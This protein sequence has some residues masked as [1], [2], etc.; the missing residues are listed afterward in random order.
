MNIVCWKDAIPGKV[1]A[2]I[3]D[4]AQ[5]CQLPEQFDTTCDLIYTWM[6]EGKI[7]GV[8]AFKTVLFS[9]GQMIPR[10]E[11]IFGTEDVRK[12][13]K[14]VKFLLSVEQQI[15]EYG[16]K[17]MWAYVTKE[18]Q[19]MYDYALKFGFREYAN[20]SKGSF[21]VKNLDKKKRRF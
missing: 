13:V 19:A 4:L 3:L 16:F 10:F 18:R 12:T 1:L 20:D 8:I 2:D 15:F 14:G 17:Q 9:D 21:L 7:V 11:H 6:E 5:E